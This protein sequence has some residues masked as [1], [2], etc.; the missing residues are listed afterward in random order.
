MRFSV[1][2]HLSQPWDDVLDVVQ[3]A[4][5]TGWEGV[6]VADHFMG[7]GT[8]FGAVDTPMLEATA[9]LGGLAAATDRVRLGS[10]VFGTT[11]RHPAVLANW[12]AS[13]DRMS[14]GRLVLGLGAGWQTNEHDQY[15]I[16]LP[17]VRE[18]VDRFAETCEVVRGLLRD[19]RTTFDGQ[20]FHLIDALCEPKPVQTPLPL[21]VGGKGDRM[22]GITARFG[23][24]WNMWSMPDVFAERS[25]ALDRRC[26]QI[27]RDPSEIHRSTQALI[28][29]TDDARGGPAV[30]GAGGPPGRGGRPHPRWPRRWPGGA[31]PVS[32]RSSSRT[33]CSAVG[34]SA[35]TRSTRSSPRS[36]RRSGPDRDWLVRRATGRSRQRLTLGT[37]DSV[38]SRP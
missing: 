34:R 27:G 18:R 32:T 37:T 15:G 24:E 1:W 35:A 30:R 10:L 3:H 33:S 12:A 11:Y 4:E 20:W 6:W 38:G 8:A 2:P 19:E 31:T 25:E 5:A 26:E 22:L 13:I 36:R 9:A 16:E 28:V 7:D 23:D 17:P 21:L 29:I 14:N